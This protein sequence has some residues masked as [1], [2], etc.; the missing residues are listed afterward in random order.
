M[1]VDVEYMPEQRETKIEVVGKP[2]ES[3]EVIETIEKDGHTYH[4]VREEITIVEEHYTV[5]TRDGTGSRS[6]VYYVC[7]ED[8]E[9]YV[10]KVHKK[11][12]RGH[13]TVQN[14]SI[15]D[16]ASTPVVRDA[17]SDHGIEVVN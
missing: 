14:T 1:T 5:R 6:R 12:P 8:D 4:K 7:R 11:P 2:T 17:L 3:Q 10:S 15:S 13:V 16:D 9:W